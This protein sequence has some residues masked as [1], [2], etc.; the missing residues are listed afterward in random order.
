MLVW[1]FEALSEHFSLFRVFS[2]L[3]FRAIITILTS[4]FLTL[5]MGPKLIR[6]L[7]DMQI[8]QVVR[9]DGPE[10]HFS[11]RGTPTMGGVMILA[12]ILISTLLWA[13]LDNAYV[14]I[15]MF[16]FVAFGAIGFV[17]DYRKVIRKDTD[18]LIA[19]WKYF[20]QS[21]IA[22]GRF[23]KHLSI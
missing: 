1:L 16:V 5:W 23:A 14:W 9:D 22:I 2:Y 4:L 19:R 15:M 18:G 21:A 12:A 7:Q 10:S 20:W 17:D 11:K 6:Y 13:R 8:G 3:T